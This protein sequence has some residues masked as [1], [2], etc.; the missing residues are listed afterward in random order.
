MNL[1]EKNQDLEENLQNLNMNKLSELHELLGLSEEYG[2]KVEDRID[3][4]EHILKKDK[5]EVLEAL[6]ELAD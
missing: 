2:Y 4:I 3:L 5:Q 1:K 6:E